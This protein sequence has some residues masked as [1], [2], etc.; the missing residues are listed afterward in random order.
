MESVTTSSSSC[1]S[2][3]RSTAPPESTGCVQYATTRA[4]PSSFSACAALTRGFAVSTLSS[5]MTQL[6]PFPSNT[7]VKAAQALKDE[8]AARSEE[9]TSELQSLTHIVCRLLL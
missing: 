3:M 1:D 6:R 7:L 2:A 8:G 9:H 4:A 5:T